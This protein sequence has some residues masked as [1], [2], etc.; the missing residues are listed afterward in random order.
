M[1]NLENKLP[2]AVG[3]SLISLGGTLGEVL[4]TVFGKIVKG[5]GGVASCPTFTGQNIHGFTQYCSVRSQPG[6]IL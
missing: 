5:P 6:G 2:S 4:N 3:A 1:I